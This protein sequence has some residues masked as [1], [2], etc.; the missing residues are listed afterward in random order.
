ME[1]LGLSYNHLPL[2]LRE[3]FLYLGG[4]PEDFKFEVKRLMWLWVA[5]GFIQQDGNRSLEDIAKGYL[6]DLVDRNLV[7]VAGRR[8]S[9]G[10][11][12]AC[13]MHDLIGSYA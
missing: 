7:I 13:K 3:C 4:F 6:M 10:G 12:K 8:K 11:L 5:E 1:T 2:H 9:N